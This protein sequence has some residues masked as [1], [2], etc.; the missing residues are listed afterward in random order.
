MV[1]VFAASSNAF[2]SPKVLLNE[3]VNAES[4]NF[5][6][7]SQVFAMQVRRWPNGVPIE[8][9]MLPKNSEVHREFVLRRLKIQP[10]QLDRIWNR[11]LFTGTGKAPTVVESEADMLEMVR[12]TPGAIGYVSVGFPVEGV[13]ALEG[14]RP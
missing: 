9:F 7:L 11:M 2:A 8:V 14:E 12:T 13:T 3:S 1:F 4:L 10:H 6:F 5:A